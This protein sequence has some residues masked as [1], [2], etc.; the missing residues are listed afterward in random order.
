MKTGN[1]GE[2]GAEDSS[3]SAADFI[4]DLARAP[5]PWARS[6]PA[7]VPSA[8]LTGDQDSASLRLLFVRAIARRNFSG[9]PFWV[10][11]PPETCAALAKVAAAQAGAENLGAGYRLGS[12]T[13]EQIGILRE[14]MLLPERPV[15]FPGSREYKHVFFPRSG[16]ADLQTHALFGEVEH[17][18]RIRT[19]GPTAPT[20]P[21][22]IAPRTPPPSPLDE[23]PDIARRFSRD[24]DSQQARETSSSADTHA[25]MHVDT[26]V[27]THIDTHTFAQSEV[28]GFLTSNPAH[29]GSGLQFE[30]GLH[31]PA[32]STPNSRRL[33][34]QTRQAL[35]ATG[36]D[37]QALSLREPG[38]TEA[39]YFRLVSRGG[40][41]I[42]GEE[43][44]AAFAEKV[45]TVLRVETDAW[46]RWKKREP[47]VIEDRMH[48]SL[49]VLQEARRM[50]Y[51][52]LQL[53]TSFARAG[54]YTGTFPLALL[55]KLE[56][57]RV[58]AQPFHLRAFEGDGRTDEGM[59]G[60]AD[61]TEFT[62]R[63]GLARHLL[64][65]L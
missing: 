10:S 58:K 61:S 30:A 9:F 4:A 19:L 14:R 2:D 15:S 46:A 3:R 43:L 11:S 17:W 49:R 33:L 56:S 21:G 25:R 18:T 23:L 27:D 62:V 32:L 42:S 44:A 24:A 54:V 55:P 35:G 41:G 26:H 1:A 40:A 63:A 29:A 57:L 13:L 60:S 34:A 31:L 28:W 53:L 5:V 65:T 8:D 52:E 16:N 51:P 38:A 64:S 45:R 47:Q 36:Y 22:R 20:E 6:L 7:D 59:P 48:R 12:L 37:L 50:E 39:G